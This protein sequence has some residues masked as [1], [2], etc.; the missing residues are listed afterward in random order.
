MIKF[1]Y[2]HFSVHILFPER[3][4]RVPVP[5][6]SQVHDLHREFQIFEG[7]G[8]GDGPLERPPFMP[9]KTPQARS[10]Y[11]PPT[12]EGRIVAALVRRGPLTCAELEAALGEPVAEAIAA[13]ALEGGWLKTDGDRYILKTPRERYEVEV[14]LHD[15][16]VVGSWSE[17]W[18]AECEARMVA[19]MPTQGQRHAYILRVRV[20]NGR[21]KGRGD[22]A[23]NELER[24]AR[25]IFKQAIEERKA[26]TD[27][28]G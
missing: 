5:L 8:Q 14:T 12:L 26:L 7:D 19:R 24:R 15:G 25:A 2:Y 3:P 4:P 22:E 16:R 18:R 17:D 23:A 6:R 13:M 10:T 1:V 27:W 21:H 28:C 20:G 9:M 11:V